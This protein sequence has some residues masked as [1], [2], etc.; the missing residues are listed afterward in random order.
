MTIGNGR[1]GGRP[2]IGP[3]YK[4]EIDPEYIKAFDAAIERG[5]TFEQV[6]RGRKGG[7]PRK[8]VADV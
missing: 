4:P 2:K 5:Q 3:I 6:H 7:R 1:K 8:K